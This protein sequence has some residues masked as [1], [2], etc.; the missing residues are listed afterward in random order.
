[1][2]SPLDRIELKREDF[3]GLRGMFVERL[4]LALGPEARTSL[5]RRLQDRLI[6]H[7][8][9]SFAEYAQF[10]RFSGAAVEEWEELQDLLTV[11]E[12]YFWRDEAQ[13]RSVRD[14]VLPLLAEQGRARRRLSIWSAGCAT[15]EEVYTLA[16]LVHESGLFRDWFVRIYGSDVSRRCVSVARRG[17]Y[18]A[19]SFRAIPPEI[20]KQYFHDR[21][22]GA[23][24]AE[25]IRNYCSFGQVN[26]AQEDKVRLVG[27]QDA[28]MCR[29]VLI[30][31]DAPARRSVTDGFLDRLNP[32]GIL[33]LGHSESLAHVSNAFE[34]LPLKGD[35]VYRKPLGSFRSA[36]EFLKPA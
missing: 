1:M 33:M 32:G 23:H 12:T 25:R 10:L 5:E 28:I 13:L 11:H 36:P 3:E 26:L 16:I 6:H 34:L 15:G 22:D 2:R 17:V 9:G 31:F 20:R 27:R 30:Y 14:E 19:P 24:V 21:P 4:G 18:G 8:H 35:L 7:G 29:N